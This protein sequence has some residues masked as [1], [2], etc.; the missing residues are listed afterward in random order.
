MNNI[1][2]SNVKDFLSLSL[3]KLSLNNNKDN[4]HEHGLV[5]CISNLYG[6]EW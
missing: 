6:K 5:N 3:L 2:Y 4:F 1:L